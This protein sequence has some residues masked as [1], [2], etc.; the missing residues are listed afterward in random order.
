MERVLRRFRPLLLV[1][2]MNP[3][4]DPGHRWLHYE[5]DL[6]IAIR[7]YRERARKKLRYAPSA[8]RNDGALS[9]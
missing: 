7:L 8:V 6:E 9:P 3:P 2:R 1:R 4:P 5:Q